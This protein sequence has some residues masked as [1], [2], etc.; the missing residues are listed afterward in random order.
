MYEYEY[1]LYLPLSPRPLSISTF[2]A[3][4]RLQPLLRRLER[5]IQ[6]GQLLQQTAALEKLL[7]NSQDMGISL[8]EMKILHDLTRINHANGDIM[9]INGDFTWKHHGMIC[10]QI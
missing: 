3:P 1:H 4:F 9:T 2:V 10:S 7:L 5:R 6:G 8:Q